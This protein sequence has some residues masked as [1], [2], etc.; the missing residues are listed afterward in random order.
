MFKR[1]PTNLKIQLGLIAAL[2]L[3]VISLFLSQIATPDS[4]QLFGLKRYQEN[5]FLKLKSNPQ[6]KLDY[7]RLMLDRRLSELSS[8]VRR[9]SYDYI[10]PSASRYSTLAGQITDLVLAN[11]LKD[12]IDP[13]KLQFINHQKVLN[14]LYEIY[15]KNTE[16]VEYKYIEDDI[17]YLKIYLEKLASIK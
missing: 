11:N 9:K 12:Q 4:P 15:P 14:S 16:N 1:L 10:L 5:S 8:Q 2:V 13:L 17:N 6:Q 7:M 3:F